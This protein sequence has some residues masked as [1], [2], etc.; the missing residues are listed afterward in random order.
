[1]TLL[2]CR[3]QC[4]LNVNG[5]DCLE[6]SQIFSGECHM[7]QERGLPVFALAARVTGGA[8]Q[9]T[10]ARGACQE[11]FRLCLWLEQQ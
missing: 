6:R 7:G 8:L 1:M 3:E 2:R 5:Y 11:G 10:G 4:S 9:G